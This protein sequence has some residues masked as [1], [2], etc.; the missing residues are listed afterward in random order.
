MKRTELFFSTLLIPVDFIMLILAGLSSYYLR[1][2]KF[3][4]SIRP[5]IFDLPLSDYLPSLFLIAILWMLVFALA[6]LYNIR[7]AR[8]L[9][10]EIGRA[11]V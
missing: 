9:A 2:S 3:S 7:S 1:F 10:Q 5:I 11:H 4:T 6:G 8:R